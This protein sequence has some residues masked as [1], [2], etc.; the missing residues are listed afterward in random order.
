MRQLILN[1]NYQTTVNEC[2]VP[3]ILKEPLHKI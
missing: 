3:I 2:Y 1:N